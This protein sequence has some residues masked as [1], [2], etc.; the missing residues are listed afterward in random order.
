MNQYE[1]LLILIGLVVLIA[2]VVMAF[3]RVKGWLAAISVGGLW[4]L[5]MA[6]YTIYKYSGFYSST[7]GL[8]QGTIAPAI[9][10]ALGFLIFLAGVGILL[11]VFR[12]TRR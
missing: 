7:G 8:A 5:A 4:L 11:Y 3:T 6:L 10:T 2:G 12:R 9:T 1:I